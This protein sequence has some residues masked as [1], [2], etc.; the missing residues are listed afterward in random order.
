MEKQ[1]LL[2]PQFRDE[3]SV[4][5]YLEKNLW[6]DGPVCPHCGV[7]GE[8]YKLQ[9]KPG[10]KNQLR[11]GVY[12]CAACRE[13][14]TV[15]VGTIFED[16]K[17][18]LHKWLLAVHL[19]CS[20]KKGIS[21][22]QLM[23]NLELGSYRTAWFMS[24]R[25][26]YAMKQ[27]P[28]TSMLTGTIEMDETY[29]GGKL[30]CGTHG[31]RPGK[32]PKDYLSPV[33]NKVAVVSVLQRGGRVQSL[34]VERVTAK[35]LKP[36][37]NQ[38]VAKDARLMTDTSTVLASAGSKRK[39]FKVN[40]SVGEYVRWE[41]GVVITTNAVEGYFAN[42]KRGI[43]GVYHQVGKQHL[44]R[45]LSEFDFRYNARDVSDGQRSLLAVQGTAGKRLM[46]RDSR[47]SA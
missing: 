21:A 24:H 43:D 45:Y 16:S 13:P 37:V 4:R 7:I 20:S 29:I 41:K 30:R 38:M 14:F 6:P 18:P 12:K 1:G 47:S 32:R 39:H 22:H 10:T 34:H 8:A 46:L 40:H 9:S 19:L 33:A 44:H 17:I 3:D 27:E 31:R 5:A 35:N 36:I 15:T 28:L 11:K 26:R 2:Q 42:L 25:I 23:R